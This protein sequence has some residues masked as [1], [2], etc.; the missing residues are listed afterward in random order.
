MT[1]ICTV[2]EAKLQIGKT[3]TTDDSELQS[4]IDS[5]TAPIEFICGPV[6]SASVTEWHHYPCS[7]V[8]VLR[9]SPVQSV[10]SI[11]EY[12]GA[13]A[14]TYSAAADPTAGGSYT[15]LLEA[16]QGKVSRIVAGG[17]PLEF[18]GR[19][20]VVYSVGYAAVPADIP[21]AAR[22][23]VQHLW[24]TQQGGAGLPSLSDEPTA[25]VPGFSYAIPQRA[26]ELLLARQRVSLP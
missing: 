1:G 19:V 18:T 16:E 6:L 14:Y 10:T 3:V 12:L 15:Y 13:T 9:T 22:L 8:L 2:A 5:I 26:A 7:D 25:V 4:Y 11:T 20:K 23:I 21:L 17:W 24:R